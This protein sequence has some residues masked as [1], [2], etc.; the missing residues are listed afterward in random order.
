MDAGGF[1]LCPSSQR[2]QIARSSMTVA[3]LG[4]ALTVG[5]GV[6]LPSH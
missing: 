4:D 2:E 1:N 5:A 3:T 6:S